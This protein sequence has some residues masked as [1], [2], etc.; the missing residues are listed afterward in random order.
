M[1][2]AVKGLGLSGC[3]GLLLGIL[4][5]SSNS[6]F[7]RKGQY[8]S[9]AV[10]REAKYSIN[11]LSR[12]AANGSVLQDVQKQNVSYQG[13]PA[14]FEIPNG[15]RHS[16]FEQELLSTDREHAVHVLLVSSTVVWLIGVLFFAAAAWS[17]WKA[18]RTL[19]ESLRARLAT[20]VAP[21]AAAP[22][23]VG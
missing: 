12:N 8:E 23:A 22:E 2:D 7:L 1:L 5:V 17:V 4:I 3:L 16:Y 10:D 20:E 15:E 13:L 19:T 14:R 21:P 6:L 9:S 18:R 11:S